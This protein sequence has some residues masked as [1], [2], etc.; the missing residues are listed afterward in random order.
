MKQMLRRFRA[1]FPTHHPVEE[2]VGEG[3]VAV[4]W[5][6]RHDTEDLFGMRRRATARCRGYGF[7]FAGKVVEARVF[8]DTRLMRQLAGS[9]RRLPAAQPGVG[10]LGRGRCS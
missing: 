9:V 1:A 4:R 8:E 2:V 10:P 5:T 6:S 7:T 3:Q